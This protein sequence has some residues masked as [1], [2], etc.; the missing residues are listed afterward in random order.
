MAQINDMKDNYKKLDDIATDIRNPEIEEILKFDNHGSL[1]WSHP[2]P[3][4]GQ[5]QSIKWRMI[6]ESDCEEF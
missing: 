3:S 5:M 1:W 6:Q 2:W 4:G